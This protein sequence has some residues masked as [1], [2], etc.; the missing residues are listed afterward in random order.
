MESQTR[1]SR[2]PR[3]RSVLMALLIGGVGIIAYQATQLTWYKGAFL[4][5]EQW[6]WVPLSP[7]DLATLGLIPTPTGASPALYTVFGYPAPQAWIVAAVVLGLL[8][9]ATRLG[10]VALFGAGAVW[11]ARQAAEGLAVTLNS[12]A[13]VQGR[14]YIDGHALPQFLDWT[15]V[16][17]AALILTACQITYAAHVARREALAAGEDVEHNL[18]DTFHAVQVSAMQRMQTAGKNADHVAEVKT[19]TSTS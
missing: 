18:L 14:F 3:R 1:T 6:T 17:M 4:N 16:L 15:W 13:E 19:P 10:V 7:L 11:M 9:V 5:G 2:N 12:S 8:A